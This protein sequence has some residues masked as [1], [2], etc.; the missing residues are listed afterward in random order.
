M[1]KQ[2]KVTNNKTGVVQYFNKTEMSRFFRE[3][4]KQVKCTSSY[5]DECFSETPIQ[6]YMNVDRL[7]ILDVLFIINTMFALSI[8]SYLLI[9]SII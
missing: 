2:C 8:L 5:T 6:D 1:N 3:K 7:S 9:K 4:N